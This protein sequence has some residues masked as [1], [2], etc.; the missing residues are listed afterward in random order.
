[1]PQARL[2]QLWSSL[3]DTLAKAIYRA[4]IPSPPNFLFS[5]CVTCATGCT[6]LLAK[7]YDEVLLFFV[8]F[9][10][11]FYVYITYLFN[12]FVYVLPHS[13][14]DMYVFYLCKRDL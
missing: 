5:L 4:V 10:V 12:F 9:L 14:A 3:Y 6:D 8:F 13:A 7:H 1:M 11:L 2:V